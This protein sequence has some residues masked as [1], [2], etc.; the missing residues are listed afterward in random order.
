MRRRVSIIRKDD[1]EHEKRMILLAYTMSMWY[2]LADAPNSFVARLM[3]SA[4]YQKPTGG[5]LLIYGTDGVQKEQAAG[6][7]RKQFKR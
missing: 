2:T 3:I 5:V 7:K 4:P 6:S 1:R